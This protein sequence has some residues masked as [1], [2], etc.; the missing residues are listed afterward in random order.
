MRISKGLD[1]DTEP[2][3]PDEGLGQRVLDPR[4]VNLADIHAYDANKYSGSTEALAMTSEGSD[5]LFDYKDVNMST[6]VSRNRSQLYNDLDNELI[7]ES[8]NRDGGYA[9]YGNDMDGVDLKAKEDQGLG[10]A[11]PKWAPLNTPDPIPY[12]VIQ[13]IEEMQ[14]RAAMNR[15]F[16]KT[17]TPPSRA[18]LNGSG[19]E[20]EFMHP[21]ER[22]PWRGPWLPLCYYTEYI[23]RPNVSNITQGWTNLFDWRPELF[24]LRNHNDY[25]PPYMRYCVPLSIARAM[26]HLPPDIRPGA[27]GVKAAQEFEERRKRRYRPWTPPPREEVV[28][29]LVGAS[30]KERDSFESGGFSLLQKFYPDVY[31]WHVEFVG[32]EAERHKRLPQS[33]G[34]MRPRVFKGMWHEYVNDMHSEGRFPPDVHS[35]SSYIEEQEARPRLGS[36]KVIRTGY[37]IGCWT[38]LG[39][40]ADSWLESLPSILDSDLPFLLLS[41]DP[42]EQEGENR[43]LRSLGSSPMGK[44]FRDPFGGGEKLIEWAMAP[45]YTVRYSSS[46]MLRK[47]YDFAYNRPDTDPDGVNASTTT[48]E[49]PQVGPFG[50]QG[51]VVCDTCGEEMARIHN[52]HDRDNL[53]E[54]YRIQR[55]QRRMAK[56]LIAQG[57]GGTL[58]G[59]QKTDQEVL[60]E[61]KSYKGRWMSHAKRMLEDVKEADY[62][63]TP[64]PTP[65]PVPRWFEE[66]IASTRQ[67]KIWPGAKEVGGDPLKVGLFDQNDEIKELKYKSKLRKL[68]DWNQL[69]QVQEGPGGLGWWW[70]GSDYD[71]KEMEILIHSSIKATK[72]HPPNLKSSIDAIEDFKKQTQLRLKQANKHQPT[73]MKYRRRI[74]GNRAP[75][76]AVSRALEAQGDRDLRRR[77]GTEVE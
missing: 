57:V 30:I 64:S 46:K 42:Y 40:I 58:E 56:K 70:K 29:Y 19:L 35:D 60:D 36:T 53:V 28:L 49:R 37:I 9:D 41:L 14:Y 12:E 76:W 25:R 61:L 21:K 16:N 77:W 31:R 68:D 6:A 32:P 22:G 20:R 65:H 15:N 23:D 50:L 67:S 27:R 48:D 43:L 3:A 10:R 72:N 44:T 11:R 47:I 74:L 24:M 8:I 62:D 51:I 18:W 73:P 13:E 54:E 71:L 52:Q 55:R 39:V 17:I 34:K 75:R 26:E 33:L 4:M 5:W 69:F 2:E 45:G 7:V 1:D 63:P 38:G 59:T 66:K